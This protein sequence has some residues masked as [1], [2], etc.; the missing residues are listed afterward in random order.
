MPTHKDMEGGARRGATLVMVAIVLVILGGMAAFAIELSRTYSGVN[1]LQTSSDAAA[2]VGAR[3]LQRAPG[4]SPVANVVSFA[5]ANSAFGAPISLASSDIEGGFWDPA[6]ST[7]SSR[8]WTTANAVRVRSA[9]TTTLAFGRLVGVPSMNPVKRG[10]AWLASQAGLDCIKP[11]GLENSFLT[12]K[13]GGDI[14]TQAGIENLRTLTAPGNLAGQA[15]ATIIAGPEVDIGTAERERPGDPI[16]NL[17]QTE[18]SALTGPS[19]SIRNYST[20]IMGG[21]CDGSSTSSYTI[22]GSGES[23]ENGRS[24]GA[25]GGAIPAKTMAIELDA[26]PGSIPTVPIRTCVDA[27]NTRTDAACYDPV[28]GAEGVD[29]TLAATTRVGTNGVTYNAFVGFR[30]LCVFRGPRT[31]GPGR[32]R[33]T[34]VCPWLQRN[35]IAPDRYYIQGTLVGY[36]FVSVARTGPG[37]T[38]GNTPGPAQKLVLVQ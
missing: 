17:P 36:P 27:P 32:G 13:L 18:Y 22:G 3:Q 31:G 21:A 28:T 37:N 20:E 5:S 2:L 26:P 14:T 34:E 10:T 4:L 6:A 30:L 12:T 25:G 11:W 23:R 29:I 7:F 19:S 8:P 35:G 15:T 9:R 16:P 24:P 1:E 38:L 33:M